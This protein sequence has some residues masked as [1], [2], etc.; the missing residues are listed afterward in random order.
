M[1]ESLLLVADR[2][3]DEEK[4]RVIG[5]VPDGKAILHTLTQPRPP[6]S[7]PPSSHSGRFPTLP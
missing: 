3:V 5:R 1:V 7:E 4:Q 6:I 2:N